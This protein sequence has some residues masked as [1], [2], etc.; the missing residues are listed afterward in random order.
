[1]SG[2]SGVSNNA[3]SNILGFDYQKFIAL[4]RCLSGKENDVIWIE[5][6]MTPTY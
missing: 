1:M 3:T 4:E 2:M 6:V 5:W